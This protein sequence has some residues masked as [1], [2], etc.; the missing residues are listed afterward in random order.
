MTRSVET[1][2]VPPTRL[3]APSDA[4]AFAAG[5]IPRRE[6]IERLGLRDYADLLVLLGDHDLVP[7][8]PSGREVG[9]QVVLIENLWR[10][11][12]A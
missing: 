7:P 10:S 4:V 6:A 5:L 9:E 3:P 1:K 11:L 8:R 12:E 2:D